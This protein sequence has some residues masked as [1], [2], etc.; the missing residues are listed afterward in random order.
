MAL[1]WNEIANRTV[2]FIKD[3]KDVK[4][5]KSEKDTFW[6]EF[7][8]IFGISRRRLATFEEPVKKLNNKTGF[9]DLFWKGTLLVEHKSKGKNLDAAFEQA[10]DYFYGI[11]E[12]E[13]PKYILVSDF[14]RFRLYDLDENINYEFYLKDLLEHIK[15]FGFIA[16]YPKKI[17]FEEDPVN[18]RAADL[19]AKLHDELKNTGYTGHYL[20]VYLVRLLFS[21]FADDTGIFEK[22]TFKDLIEY[23][24]NDDG[25]DLGTW[26]AYLFQVL[27]TPNDKRLKN[28]DEHLKPFPF[29]NG[30]LFEEQ[31]PIASFNSEMR[32][33]ILECCALNWGKISP[34][35]FGSM[36]Q[37]VM[38][39]KERRNFGA[40]YTSEKNILKLINPLFMN[41]LKHEFNKIKNNKN[42]LKEFHVKLSKLTFLDPAC[43][44][45]NFLIISYRELRLLELEILKI[46]YGNQ[47]IIDISQFVLLNVDKFYGIEIDEWPAKIA[48]VAMWLIDHQMNLNVSEEFGQYF[49]R[50]PLE[51]SA[52]IIN[53]NA[54]EI[55]WA[56]ITQNAY[57]IS[58][59]T[60]N[61]YQINEP[62][63]HYES[64]NVYTKSINIK[65]SD[66]YDKSQQWKFIPEGKVDF[67]FG[68][69]PFV[70]S[71]F[72]NTN[73]RNEMANI[74][75]G[76]KN[77]KILD[78]VS[79][80][81]IK[82]AQYI[83]N[84]KTKCAYV[85]T[86]SITQGEQVGVLWKLLFEKYKIKI[87]FAHKTFKWSNEGK[88]VANVYCTIIGFS[89]YNVPDKE[90]YIYSDING[91][92]EKVIV[93]NIN[94]YL[95]EADDVF[96]ERRKKPISDIP[97][98]CFGN[99][100][101]DSGHLIFT[102]KEKDDFI[103]SEPKSEKWF[104]RLLGAKELLYNKERWCLWFKDI[105]PAELRKMPKVME[106]VKKVQKTRLKAKDT[107]TQKLA[108][109]PYQFR[110]T[111]NPDK[112]IAIPITTGE[113]RVYI[114]IVYANKNYIPAVTIQT[115][116]NADLYIFGVLQSKMHMNWVKYTCGRLKNDYR[117][118][119]DL[120]YNNFPFPEKVNQIQR[121]NIIQASEKI[122]NIRNKY[123]N[124]SLADLYDSLSMP[125]DLLK[126]HQELD[127]FVDAAYRQKAFQNESERLSYLFSLYKQILNI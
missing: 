105:E 112:Y 62:V 26:I 36:F 80:W 72:L 70:G 53:G 10:A 22:D 96:L 50:L 12:H 95:V 34:A 3:W 81:Y 31:L 4:S 24:T 2:K 103:K 40:H 63:P 93:K 85:S 79:A 115:I 35:I 83:E 127:D 89:N 106:R 74:F 100:A 109:R 59:N 116:A 94:P 23:R 77:G 111:N 38:N 41:D 88:N 102:D 25:S 86:N 82:A 27:N 16:G 125:Y 33:L 18:I 17:H 118:S 97:E 108:Q 78:Y 46:L 58:S 113:S 68:N 30:K 67:I 32:E 73:Q 14:N 43:G 91:E 60:T 126:S 107:G 49:I 20:E 92:P 71:K 114:P 8:N 29:V 101:L 56:N 48:E 52:Q 110:D 9:I 65:K 117:Y 44:C 90:L 61:V 6:N 5:E 47:Q 15:L 99:V 7:F 42:I 66:I 123:S 57:N 98:M 11:K 124:N 104:K 37:S 64:V 122:L 1:S 119:K 54:L 120:V 19:M 84:A 28:L 55:D 45:G 21:M 13:L 75:S 76:I 51:K 87:H 39:P 121:K 69:P